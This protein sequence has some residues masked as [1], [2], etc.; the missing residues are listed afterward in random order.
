MATTFLEDLQKQIAETIQQAASSKTI[1]ALSSSEQPNAANP[2]NS[3]FEP[4]YSA[5]QLSELIF[6]S[7]QFAATVLQQDIRRQ[8]NRL[9][10]PANQ[11][12]SDP[13]DA[14]AHLSA[15]IRLN[16]WA[17]P[18]NP[19]VRQIF[20]APTDL[21]HEILLRDLYN[22]EIRSFQLQDRLLQDKL[23]SSK[24][25]GLAQN[26][27]QFIKQLAQNPQTKER[28]LSS[29]SSQTLI[30]SLHHPLSTEFLTH[31]TRTTLK[32]QFATHLEPLTQVQLSAIAETRL[33]STLALKQG[34]KITL[35]SAITE[36]GK[37]TL[38][39]LQT[40]FSPSTFPTPK[41]LALAAIGKLAQWLPSLSP[42]LD[43]ALQKA[44][45]SNLTG[46]PGQN[47]QQVWTRAHHQISK[48]YNGLSPAQK[49]DTEKVIGLLQPSLSAALALSRLQ[50]PLQTLTLDKVATSLATGQLSST[51]ALETLAAL[52]AMQQQ[53]ETDKKNLHIRVTPQIKTA[54][55]AA[56]NLANPS[57]KDPLKT[58]LRQFKQQGDELIAKL[59]DI[60]TNTPTIHADDNTPLNTRLERALALTQVHPSLL[61]GISQN[62]LA[63][64]IINLLKPRESQYQSLNPLY[65]THLISK[66]NG[67]EPSPLLHAALQLHTQ[68][69]SSDQ[70]LA[71]FKEL[72][73]KTIEQSLSV[74]ST[75]SPSETKKRLSEVAELLCYRPLQPSPDHQQIQ[76]LEGQI[77]SEIIRHAKN[78][79]DTALEAQFKNPSESDRRIVAYQ[80]RKQLET[81][82]A[83]HI[84]RTIRKNSQYLEEQ[85]L[86]LEYAFSSP[87]ELAKSWIQKEQATTALTK[88]QQTQ[89]SQIQT[90]IEL[91]QNALSITDEA[92]N[93][94]TVQQFKE[95]ITNAHKNRLEGAQTEQARDPFNP[96]LNRHL[97]ELTEF[98][99]PLE[100]GRTS[101]KDADTGGLDI[102]T[103]WEILSKYKQQIAKEL[104]QLETQLTELH[105]AKKTLESSAGVNAPES[106][107]RTTSP[108]RSINS[109]S[110]AFDQ[111]YKNNPDTA[112]TLSPQPFQGQAIEIILETAKAHRDIEERTQKLNLYW[113]TF[114]SNPL[115]PA[116]TK[117]NPTEAIKASAKL[118]IY[119][120][121]AQ[122]E[123]P[124]DLP[125]SLTEL[126]HKSLASLQKIDTLQH[127]HRKRP[128]EP[129]KAR[130]S[131]SP[132]LSSI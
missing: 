17:H 129:P 96:Q 71:Q 24:K 67:E 57:D 3:N 79:N 132:R 27:N 106:A 72:L 131:A 126:T 15:I 94:Q 21:T 40:A 119:Q 121:L 43:S 28:L 45:Y 66:A 39:A 77:I 13:N 36:L 109:L 22:E 11:S 25:R 107:T 16:H 92:K 98:K 35:P 30:S 104:S 89:F 84:W 105:Y 116:N 8:T 55:T 29:V 112:H 32:E 99:T 68:S 37:Q 91:L 59:K 23:L 75:L 128:S 2:A 76:H 6:Y 93:F 123:Q 54:A 87:T 46:L 41:D 73:S 42:S 110:A 64:Q 120:E 82:Q 102:R 114:I 101:I 83:D 130:T 113:N 74:K 52:V 14:L 47:T 19:T 51:S 65:I 95:W 108:N 117:A 61:Q 20:S 18:Q 62:E 122:N 1:S 88:S 124:V 118:L 34:Q 69:P 97:Q 26:L 44:L 100:K 33:Q 78:H 12:S 10:L 49:Q 56:F 38:N 90:R 85:R 103:L 70:Q 53:L 50:H 111:A 115:A 5:D 4:I 31:L 81:A 48:I 80:A 9:T 125:P 58:A 86:N 7:A 63:N 127:Q 60:T